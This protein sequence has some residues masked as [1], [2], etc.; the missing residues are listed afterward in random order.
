M[1]NNPLGIFFY[2]ILRNDLS[3][4]LLSPREKQEILKANRGYN[5]TRPDYFCPEKYGNERKFQGENWD[6]FVFDGQDHRART[7]LNILEENNP[8]TVLEIG[9]GAGYYTRMICQYGSVVEYTAVDV[10]VAFLNYLSPRLD[11]LSQ[12]KA[13]KYHLLCGD[14]LESGLSGSYDLIVLISTVHHIPDRDRLFSKLNRLLNEKGAI[15][16]F[17]PSHYLL[18]YLQ[19]VYKAL[20]KGYLKKRYY[21]NRENISTH[22]MCTKKEYVKVLSKI[23]ELHI[24]SFIFVPSNR[25]KTI[26]RF[27]RKLFSKEIGVIIKK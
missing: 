5:V 22:H 12:K 24:D 3:W 6:S 8:E 23:P 2:L 27:D 25:Y 9:P 15:F 14:I 10:G 1:L 11:D 20:T 4:R 21:S 26:F 16:C 7:L 18:R 13:L 17:D 19:I